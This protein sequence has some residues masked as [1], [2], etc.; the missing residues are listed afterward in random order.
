V[1][2]NRRPCYR[3]R[4]GENDGDVENDI[5]VYGGLWQTRPN[6]VL[7]FLGKAFVAWAFRVSFLQQKLIK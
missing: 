2:C 6:E 4:W 1:R 7:A 3:K 5:Q